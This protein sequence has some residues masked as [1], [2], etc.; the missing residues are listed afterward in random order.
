MIT[1]KLGEAP[2]CFHPHFFLPIFLVISGTYLQHM[3]VRNIKRNN[4]SYKSNISVL[5]IASERVCYD[6]EFFV[7]MKNFTVIRVALPAKT[8]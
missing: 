2:L 3:C 7:M 4:H 5:A 1:K 6:E 8:C